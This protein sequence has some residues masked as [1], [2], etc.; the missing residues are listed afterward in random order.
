M[1]NVVKMFGRK[2]EHSSTYKLKQTEGETSTY[3][4]KWSIYRK[5]LKAMKMGESWEKWWV[6][7][8]TEGFQRGV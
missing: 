1:D 5:V 2:T 7:K 4:Y 6:F 8:I 3:M